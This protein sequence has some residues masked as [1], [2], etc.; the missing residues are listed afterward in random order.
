MLEQLLETWRI[1]QRVHRFILEGIS[2]E[3]LTCTLSTRGGRSVV[4][5]FCHVHNVRLMQLEKRAKHLAPGLVK[6]ASKEEP[7]RARLLD[8]LDESAVRVEEWL[9]LAAESDP[10]VRTLRPGVV[11][12]LGYLIAHESH[13]RGSVLLTLKQCGHAVPR[14]L[15]DG[16]WDWNTL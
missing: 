6:F 2:D 7:T 3:G 1:N 14:E 13:H 4:R 15:R 9:R 12:T 8:A 16:M 10:R 11:A 5:Q